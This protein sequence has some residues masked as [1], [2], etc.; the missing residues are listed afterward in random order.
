[1]SRNPR[2]CAQ[3][4]LALGLLLLLFGCVSPGQRP[5]QGGASQPQEP[6]RIGTFSR[7]IDYAPYMVA[8]NR[9]WFEEAAVKYGKTVEYTEFQSLPVINEALAT[10]NLDVVFEAEPPAIIGYAA[11]VDVRIKDVGVSLVQE[12]VVTKDGGIQAVENLKGK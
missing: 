4:L 11:G 6:V 8:K 10:K 1:M 7:A 12:V 9:G 5:G 3:T 2:L